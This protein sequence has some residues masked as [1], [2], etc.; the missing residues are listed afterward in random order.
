MADR[1][2]RRTEGPI[3]EGT[4]PLMPSAQQQAAPTA[5]P[6][7]PDHG[8]PS[9]GVDHYDLALTYKPASNHL[10][11]RARI[12]LRPLT[13][14][15]QLT[16]DLHALKVTKLALRGARVER[17]RQS[18]SRLVVRL[19]APV[20]AGTVPELD[21]QYRGEPR[22]MPGPDGRA[23]WEELADGVIVASQPHGS[24]TW[25]PCNDR[26]DDKARYDIAI[27]AP[28]DYH[29]LANG[30]LVGT[31]R[32]AGLVSWHY[33][34]SEPMAPYLA[35][36]AIGRYAAYPLPTAPGASVP[37]TLVCPPLLRPQ[38]AEAF[39][40]QSA[41]IAFFERLFGPYPFTA[42]YAVV[43]TPDALEIPLES[44]GLS[45]FGSNLATRDWQSQRLIAHE[46]SH[47]WF[48]NAVTARSLAEIWLH[49]GFACYSEWLWSQESGGPSAD[50]WARRY[51]RSL[52][53]QPQDLLLGAPGADRMF[54]DRVYKRGALTLHAL[55]RL[56][57]D[58]AF[59]TLL[60]DWL[61]R[62]RYG[63]AGT[64]EFIALAEQVSGRSLAGFFHAWLDS[65]PL[66]ALD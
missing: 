46:L 22:T 34:M 61:Q 39:A 7:L 65:A 30:T 17:W 56:I 35:T 52:A 6:Y 31:R 51:R 45:T 12:T 4:I 16:L 47:Q 5:D 24:P 21:V 49:E 63:V 33:R 40:D 19:G 20:A 29:V 37:A 28:T 38:A 27:S 59:F 50:E 25:F 8:D 60:R 26:A 66:P 13:E 23:G 14:I 57:G 32:G 64:A 42:D 36:V 55:R 3:E 62:Y 48:G 18:A 58:G 53:R 10:S 11:G 41:M 15:R 54:D 43:V 2:A 9:Y 44:Q 1:T